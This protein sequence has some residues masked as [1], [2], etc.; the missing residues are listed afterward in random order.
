[1]RFGYRRFLR[2]AVLLVLVALPARAQSAVARWKE[3]RRFTWGSAL[4]QVEASAD[5]DQVVEI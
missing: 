5:Y 2:S 3:I 4:I 1:M